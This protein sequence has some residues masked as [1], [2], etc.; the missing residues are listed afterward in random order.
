MEYCLEEKIGEPELFTD[1]KRE[2]AVLLKCIGGTKR[3]LSKSAAILSRRKM[4]RPALMQ[5]LYNIAFNKI[6]RSD[7]SRW[8]EIF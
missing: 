4:G 1:R 3:K 7:D 6:S 5:R 2:L 8:M